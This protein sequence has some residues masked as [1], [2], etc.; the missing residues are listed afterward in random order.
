MAG[1]HDVR[2]SSPA[3]LVESVRGAREQFIHDN[4]LAALDMEAQFSVLGLH[5]LTKQYLLRSKFPNGSNDDSRKAHIRSLPYHDNGGQA[6]D[7][8]IHVS[9]VSSLPVTQGWKRGTGMLVDYSTGQVWVRDYMISP[10]DAENINTGPDL[11]WYGGNLLVVNS[12]Q[13]DATFPG[14]AEH[15]AHEISP[16]FLAT[17]MNPFLGG[18]LMDVSSSVIYKQYQEQAAVAA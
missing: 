17:A 10:D 4:P 3:A 15:I 18:Q 16:D 11:R 2:F 12:A 9:V 5:D 13:Y 1:T 6:Y 14:H 7:T 8:M